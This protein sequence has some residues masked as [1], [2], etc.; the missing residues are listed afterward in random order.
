[1]RYN[2]R[3]CLQLAL[4]MPALVLAGEAPVSS[5]HGKN[6]AQGLELFKSQVRA[7]LTTHCVSCHG[8][9]NKTKGGLDLTTRED[10]LKGGDEGP[11]IVIGKHKDSLLWKMVSHLEEPYMPEKKPKLPAADIE[12]IAQWID[13]GA[14][15]DKPLIEKKGG[16]KN[17][18][19][20]T[21]EDRQYWSFAPL[22]KSDA[23]AVKNAAWARTPLDRFVLAKLD[24]KG[25]TPNAPAEKR[26]LIRRA[27]LD[28]IGVP[29]SPEEVTAFVNDAAPDAFDKVI[30]RLLANPHFGERWG[31]HWL[32]LARYA[33]SHGYE[34]DYDRPNAFHYR[35]F[36]IKA[37][38]ADMPYD[39]FV[40][41]QIA[42]DELAPE[43]PMALMATGF[44]AAGTHATQIT[45]NQAE[46]ERYDELDDKAATVG[47][48]MLGVTIGCARCHDHKFDPIPTNDYY[49][50]IS[51]FTTTVRSDLPIDLDPEK[52]KTKRAEWD[53]EHAPLLEALQSFEKMELPNRIE[54][55]LKS[56]PVPPQPRWVIL[57]FAESK[58]A[59]KATFKRQEDGSYLVSGENPNQETFTFTATTP[60]TRITAVK[61]EALADKSLTKSG[62]GRADNG[63]FALTTFKVAAAPLKGGAEPVSV[64]L[65]NPKA[66]FEQKSLGIANTID[67]D[68]T[69]GWAVDPEFG[70]DHAAVFEFEQPI[71]FDGG[72]KLTFTLEFKNNVKHAIGRPRLS[73]STQDLPAP[74]SGE[75]MQQRTVDGVLEALAVP[76]E[77]RTADQKKI[78]LGY[79]KASDAD[80][81]KL[82]QAVTEHDK[83]MPQPELTKV[84]ICSEGVPAVRLHTQGPDFYDKTYYLKRGDLA[85]KNGEAPSGFLQV[86]SRNP[87]GDK[88]WQK[89]PPPNSKL[90]YRRSG[91]ANWITDVDQGA[92]HLLARVIVNRLWLQHF[93]RGIVNTPSDFGNMG[94]KP[95]HPELLDYLASELIAN[96][97]RLKPIHK[98]MLQSAVYQ[99]S[100]A[101]DEA[102]TKLDP[103]NTLFW[104]RNV[105]RLE[106][107][108]IRDSILS[109]SGSLDEKMFGAGTLDLGMKRRSIYFTIKRSRLISLMS[110]FD[111]PDTLQSLPRR[112]TTV[113]A[114]Q[115]MALMNNTHIRIA[116]QTFAQRVLKESNNDA[117][118]AIQRAYELALSRSPDADE[119]DS[120]LA[121]VVAQT[122]DYKQAGKGNA[123]E[124]AL[125]NFAQLL[126]SLNEFSYVE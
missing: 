40:K 111:G 118:A 34:Q 39:Q 13:L 90:S 116:A 45:A 38:N 84:L 69:S 27:Y 33:E 95:T 16:R 109:V 74:L 46:K 67:A 110:L 23:P 113:V 19:I 9:N 117:R 30:D 65:V 3:P 5:D 43:N 121:F 77:A 1:M 25:L 57:D 66:T 47:T 101:R 24:A 50:M 7:L 60:N 37:L 107:E 103:D 14:P 76:A 20:V 79:F 53:R 96:G 83:K 73:V 75:A 125:T 18:D 26:V 61:L 54:A 104:R 85:Q 68:A 4:L 112:A 120:S 122:E 21:A 94:E 6:M 58:A 78:L 17:K 123:Q 87:D 48:A 108:A 99:Q 62:P 59:S 124:L 29:P 88:H 114:P 89:T 106:G 56:K 44:L 82:Q 102:R 119:L 51:T 71:T 72:A 10:L 2:I 8:D 12:K 49:R 32:D 63:N 42:G 70:K 64:K 36:V 92:G 31:R 55:W 105:Q 22:K 35:D 98:L 52:T 28:M 81:Q 15:Y 86:L 91:L 11:S 80:F 126:V 100:A 41:W 115:A 97:W 93:G